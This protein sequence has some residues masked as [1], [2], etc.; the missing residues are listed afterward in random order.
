[1]ASFFRFYLR[2]RNTYVKAVL[3]QPTQAGEILI[4]GGRQEISVDQLP[5]SISSPADGSKIGCVGLSVAVEKLVA[6][7]LNYDQV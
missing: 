1:M 4:A 7:A 2:V 5:P 6:C 3:G